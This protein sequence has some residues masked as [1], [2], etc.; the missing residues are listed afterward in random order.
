VMVFPRSFSGVK[1]MNQL[2]VIMI[3][4]IKVRASGI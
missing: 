1:S 2:A 4:T 3:P